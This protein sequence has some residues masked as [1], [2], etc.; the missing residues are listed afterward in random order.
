MWGIRFLT[1][2]VRVLAWHVSRPLD[3]A[4]AFAYLIR[5]RV[6]VYFLVF[7]LSKHLLSG[8]TSLL[9]KFRVWTNTPVI[10][11]IRSFLS[12]H[13]RLFIANMRVLCQVPLIFGMQMQRNFVVYLRGIFVLVVTYGVNQAELSY[14]C[15]LHNFE[16]NFELW[17]GIQWHYKVGY[18][19]VTLPRIV[20]P[21]RDSVD[22]TR[23]RVTY[24]KL[25]TR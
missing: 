10:Y 21:Y 15:W 3:E 5:H 24:Q 16:W 7:Y 12:G 25:V 1:F 17:L 2:S 18:T 20:T 19:P 9:D 4:H 22:G 6:H 14:S 11:Y 23:D 13:N 8:W